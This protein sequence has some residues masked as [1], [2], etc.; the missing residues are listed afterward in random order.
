[1]LVQAIFLMGLISNDSLHINF[2]VNGTSGCGLDLS[3]NHFLEET[4]ISLRF[5]FFFYLVHCI[6]GIIR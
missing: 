2:M 5:F 3:Q 4:Q 1:M 6:S